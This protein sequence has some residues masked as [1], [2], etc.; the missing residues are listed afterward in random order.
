MAQR[1]AVPLWGAWTDTKETPMYSSTDAY[2][3]FIVGMAVFGVCVAGAVAILAR[4]N[5][6]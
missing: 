4:L 5:T 6:D 1:W 2:A 3:L